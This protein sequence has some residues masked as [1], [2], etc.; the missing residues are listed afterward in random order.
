LTT[1]VATEP[2][3]I[4]DIIDDEWTSIRISRKTQNHLAKFALF[5]DNWNT[6]LERALKKADENENID[7]LQPPSGG[8]F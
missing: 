6:A 7:K 3:V 8:S 2:I 1:T 5:R 4:E